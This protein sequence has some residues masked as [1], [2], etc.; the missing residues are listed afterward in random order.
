MNASLRLYPLIAIA[1]AGAIAGVVA[2]V[3]RGRK[4]PG[5]GLGAFLERSPF[6]QKFF[7]RSEHHLDRS[8]EWLFRL[9]G[10]L[11]NRP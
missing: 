11:W 9:D 10:R 6:R 3:R 5:L 8:R 4:T 2:L 1:A 7:S